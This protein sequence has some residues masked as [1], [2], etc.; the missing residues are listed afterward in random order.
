MVALGLVS[1]PLGRFL[2][3]MFQWF[4]M[5]SRDVMLVW[6]MILGFTTIGF[7]A[8]RLCPAYTYF[9]GAYVLSAVAYGFK[10]DTVP[11]VTM[12]CLGMALLVFFAHAWREHKRYILF[13]LLV[14][15]LTNLFFAT[16]QA[17]ISDLGW[18][19][20]AG[21]VFRDPFF[22]VARHITEVEGLAS[23][24]SL[25]SGF[26]VVA[27]PLLVVQYPWAWLLVP[28]VIA[29]VFYAQHRASA[30]ALLTLLWVVPKRYLK[31]AV[32]ILLIVAAGVLYVRGS[33]N[34][35]NAWTGDRATVWTIT[36]AKALQKP[37]MGWGPGMFNRWRPT[38]VT[39]DRKSGLTFR[40]AHNEY[41]QTQFD[42][43]TLGSLAIPLWAVLMI[44][45]LRKARPWSQGLRGAVASTVALSLIAFISFPFRIG[46]TALAGIVTLA[47]LHGELAQPKPCG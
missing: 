9:I 12:L 4:L 20:P 44:R 26:L 8:W 46:M 30:L 7:M 39:E 31:H 27:L 1:A 16:M 15:V 35:L 19:A 11:N 2:L 3:P 34:S 18:P 29:H 5:S 38:F 33:T 45:R 13:G 43:G 47:A 22:A 32:I 23:H 25:L 40:Q 6:F 14:G 41:L 36:L 17:T 10:G 37:W 28:P 21:M 42:V 24:Y